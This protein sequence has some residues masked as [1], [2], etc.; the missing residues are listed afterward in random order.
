MSPPTKIPSSSSHLPPKNRF[1]T[2][3]FVFCSQKSQNLV[4][5]ISDAVKEVY[6][7]ASAASLANLLGLHSGGD[8]GLEDGGSSQESGD[9]NWMFSAATL[10]LLMDTSKEVVI[11]DPYRVMTFSNHRENLAF[12]DQ[13]IFIQHSLSN[14]ENT[15]TATKRK[16]ETGKFRQKH[17]RLRKKKKI[18]STFSLSFTS[19]VKKP[20]PTPVVRR[21]KNSELISPEKVTLSFNWIPS[22]TNDRS[23]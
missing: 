9:D 11:S 20:T 13:N 22:N 3:W 23:D 19:P 15:G 21:K 17:S 16:N 4:L 12:G 10:P 1:H 7:H 5:Q 18:A 2:T 14:K 6:L 8:S